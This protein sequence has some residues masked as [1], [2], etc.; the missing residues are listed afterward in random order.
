MQG[1]K[2][3]A[4]E[5]LILK[6]QRKYDEEKSGKSFVPG[7]KGDIWQGPSSRLKGGVK[8]WRCEH[9]DFIVKP[10]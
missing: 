10:N 8:A 5:G 9:G 6:G 1:W 3:G 4:D 2:H 7:K